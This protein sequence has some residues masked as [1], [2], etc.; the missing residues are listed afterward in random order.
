MG[1]SLKEIRALYAPKKEEVLC[2]PHCGH[3]LTVDKT[4]FF[5]SRICENCFEHAEIIDIADCCRN[6]SVHQVKYII[7]GGG[8]QVR[9]QCKS[10]GALSSNSIAVSPPERDRLPFADLSLKETLSD[11][12]FD[13]RRAERRRISDSKAARL[14]SDWMARYSQYLLSPGW[15]EKRDLVLKRDKYVCQACLNAL[16]T[17]VHHKSYEFVDL[18][19]NEPAFDLVSVCTPCHEKIEQMKKDRRNTQ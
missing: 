6:K 9:E 17:Q 19:G 3:D 13:F 4:L 7:S 11:K 8:I 5:E 15:R 2:C 10:C 12:A 16:A 18:A 14:K 1:L